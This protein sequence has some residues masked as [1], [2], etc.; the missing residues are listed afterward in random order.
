VSIDDDMVQAL[1]LHQSGVLEDAERGYLEL[2]RVEPGLA[3][4]RHLLGVLKHQRG[5]PA[6]GAGLIRAAILQD[7]GEAVF[8]GNL[9]TLL[10]AMADPLAERIA[11]RSL[12]LTPDFM[13]GRINLATA[14]LHRGAN[15]EAISEFH[16]LLHQSPER[17]D[18]YDRLSNAME[19]NGQ[20]DAALPWRKR[21][22]CISPEDALVYAGVANNL[23]MIG[24]GEEARRQ[25]NRGRVLKPTAATRFRA[26]H[27]QNRVPRGLAEIEES[28]RRLISFLDHAE[29]DSQFIEDPSREI[30]VTNFSYTYHDQNNR[31]LARRIANFYLSACPDLGWTAPHC[32]QRPS[33]KRRPRV[34]IVSVFLGSHTIGKLFGEMLARL[35]RD[36]FEVVA[37]SHAKAN[38]PAWID[39]MR[40]ADSQIV[41]SH[42]LAQARRQIAS[43]EA[44]ILLYLDIGMD[45]FTYYLAFARLAPVQAVCVGH[46]DTTGVPNIDY[47]LTTKGAEPEGWRD[48][49]TERA[50][51]LDEFPFFYNRPPE[52]SGLRGRKDLGLPAGATL[53]TCPQTLFKMHPSH[54]DVFVEILRR[55][56][57]GRLMLIESAQVLE[58]ER[59]HARLAEA[60]PDVINRVHFQ[61]RMDGLEYLGFVSESDLLIETFGFAGGNSTYEALSTGTPILAYAG[62]HM[63][64]RVTM[65]LLDMIGLGDCVAEDQEGFVSKALELA[66]DTSTR[67]EAR[68]RVPEATP[69]LFERQSAVDALAAFLE[70]SIE[71]S[72]RG[73]W[74]EPGR[75][76]TS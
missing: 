11:Q 47:F 62:K 43:V 4:V 58:T 3:Q 15:R 49:Y 16:A 9:S 8:H 28:R 71:A 31:D 29:T 23:M 22:S 74:L 27:V 56:P 52:T 21:Q 38:D 7:P 33:P 18:L 26:A 72:G 35:P 46:P 59:M 20:F 5:D 63:R 45:P 66:N 39:Q 44:D 68:R 17:L 41:L 73:E 48:H 50:I 69:G 75:L 13:D 32:R 36:R 34:L 14:R 6:S 12:V 64:A 57:N 65:D 61:P 70:R 37:A 60:G 54:D 24:D 2:L 42:D 19:A 76:S 53:Y 40:G 51:L 10:I 30:G 67:Q 25:L 1:S 55:D